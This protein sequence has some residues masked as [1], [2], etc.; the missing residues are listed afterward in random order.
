MRRAICPQTRDT[1]VAERASGLTARAHR[2]RRKG[3]FRRASVALREACAL[4]EQHAPRW[5]WLGDTLARLGRRDEAELAM[6]QALYL[7]VMSAENAKANVI[8]R[9]LLQLGRVR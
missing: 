3:E 2:L 1:D 8:R 6:K 7:R 4:D 5:L 9:L